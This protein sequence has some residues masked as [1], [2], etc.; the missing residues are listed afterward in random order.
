M[1]GRGTSVLARARAAVVG[2]ALACSPDAAPSPAAPAAPA[3]PAP[4][5]LSATELR[6]LVMTRQYDA[7][8][9]AVPAQ[10]AAARERG[11]TLAQC[12]AIEGPYLQAL[13]HVAPADEV[14]ARWRADS[15]EYAPVIPPHFVFALTAQAR[16]V[17]PTLELSRRLFAEVDVALAE[18]ITELMQGLTIEADIY[19]HPEG[20][21][22]A[23]LAPDE[24]PGHWDDSER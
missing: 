2:A 22:K 13:L 11:D 1:R 17:D 21:P 7:V 18:T 12:W 6:Q 5:A 8:V 20:F 15:A 14:V 4:P 23:W 3:P 16:R 10:L 9:A 19:G 24:R